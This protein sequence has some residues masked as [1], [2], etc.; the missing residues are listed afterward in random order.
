MKPAQVGAYSTR[1]RARSPIGTVARSTSSI[2]GRPTIA[3]CDSVIATPWLV[4]RSIA[5]CPATKFL[6]YIRETGL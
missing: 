4:N 1:G 2:C 6:S 5:A 3:N